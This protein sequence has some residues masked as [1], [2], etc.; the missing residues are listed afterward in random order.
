LELEVL[1]V[2]PLGL[3]IVRCTLAEAALFVPK[4]AAKGSKKVNAPANLRGDTDL[5][6]RNMVRCL[7]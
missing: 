1:V 2:A 7:D 6:L 3:P 5:N 4:K